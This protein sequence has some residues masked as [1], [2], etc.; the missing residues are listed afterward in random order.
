[1]NWLT[2]IIT[3]YI[4]LSAEIGLRGLLVIGD[5][6]YPGFLLI[7]LVFIG[8]AA[9]HHTVGWAAL[10]LGLLVDLQPTTGALAVPGPAAIGYLVGGYAILQLRTLLF[11]ESVLTLAIMVFAVGI[12]VNLAEVALYSFRGLGFLAG[13]PIP[14]WS[15]A[16]ELVT[17]FL[18][19]LYTTVVAIPLG[20]VLVKTTPLWR[21]HTGS[22]GDRSY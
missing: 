17:R 5:Q 14:G 16:G 11:R 20:W 3:T 10:I 8:L 22:R 12:F 21:F 9:S 2:F 18:R 19:L 4:L 15:A 6:V 1:M 13:E 7:L